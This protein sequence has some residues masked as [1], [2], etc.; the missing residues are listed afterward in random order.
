MSN[1]K[2][3]NNL[4]PDKKTNTQNI[5]RFIYSPTQNQP[6]ITPNQLP[7]TLN[8]PPITLN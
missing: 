1:G 8:Q 2:Q 7:I 6:P 4:T 5:S 3:K